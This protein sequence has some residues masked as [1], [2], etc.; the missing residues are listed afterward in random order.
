LWGKPPHAS[1]ASVDAVE[2]QEQLRRGAVAHTRREFATAPRLDLTRCQFLDA[3]LPE[4]GTE[5]VLDGRFVVAQRG[6]TA[7]AL[8]LGVA[9]P[10]VGGVPKVTPVR[11]RPGAVPLRI[12][13]RWSYSHASALRFVK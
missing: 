7:T 3:C 4:G 9:Q 2:N 1:G 6:G 11:I 10:L 5:M 12:E 13:A 8:V